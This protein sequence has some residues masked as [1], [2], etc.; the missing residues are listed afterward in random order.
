ME[1]PD[2]LIRLQRSAD[3]EGRRLE[4]LDEDERDAQRRVHFNAAA[5]VEVAVRDFAASAGLDRHTVEKELRQ[6]ARHPRAE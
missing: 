3:D 2:Y 5:E 6:R 4:R 1:L